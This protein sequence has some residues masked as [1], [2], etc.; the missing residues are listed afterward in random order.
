MSIYRKDNKYSKENIDSLKGYGY[1]VKRVYINI[2]DNKM[3]SNSA[4]DPDWFAQ[5]EAQLNDLFAT[6]DEIG[7]P[8]L[9][10]ALEALD[11]VFFD[12]R[13]CY[14]YDE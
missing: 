2:E 10:E 1:D 7:N 8:S 12:V 11:E 9:I 4:G 5:A 3:N 6:F 14:D 13:K